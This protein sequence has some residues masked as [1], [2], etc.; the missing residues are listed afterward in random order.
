[1]D[2]DTNNVSADDA[3]QLYLDHEYLVGYWIRRKYGSCLP[4]DVQNES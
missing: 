4:S 3:E 1:M 2:E